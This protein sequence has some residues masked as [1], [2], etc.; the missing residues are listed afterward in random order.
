MKIP[1]TWMDVTDDL[2]IDVKV[3]Q[4]LRFDYEDSPIVIKIT[5]KYNKR[6]WARHLDPSKYLTPEESDERVRVTPKK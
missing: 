2:P 1:S 3:G 4:V 5:S 6:V